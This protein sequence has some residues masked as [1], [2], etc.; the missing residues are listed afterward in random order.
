MKM[1]L[2]FVAA[3]TLKYG[4]PRPDIN[5]I[6]PKCEPLWGARGRKNTCDAMCNRKLLNELRDGKSNRRAGVRLLESTL[7]ARWTPPIKTVSISFPRDH[8]SSQASSSCFVC[9]SPLEI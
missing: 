5:S 7:R 2:L 1:R 4:C 8:S 6:P 3:F 9:A